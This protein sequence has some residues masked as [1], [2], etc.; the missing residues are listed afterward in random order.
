MRFLVFFTVFTVLYGSMNLYAFVRAKNALSPGPVIS[1]AIGLFLLTMVFSHFLVHLFQG[2]D[3]EVLALVF[4]YAGYTWMAFL[5]LFFCI[6]LSTDVLR[7]ILYLTGFFLKGDGQRF[8]L[9]PKLLFWAG[10][11][12]AMMITCYGYFE[13]LSIKTERITIQSPKIP[14]Q[15]GKIKVAQI[16][17]V[18]LG[19]MVR[20]K[21]L[22]R[23]LKAVRKEN[24][25]ILVSTGDLI[26][27][28]LDH[29]ESA[30]E[31]FSTI[32]PAYG[33]YAVTGN[34][35]FYRGIEQSVNITEQAGFRVLRGE[36][37]KIPGLLNIAGVDDPAGKSFESVNMITEKEVLST[38]PGEDFTILLKHQP[39]LDNASAGLFDLQLS[40]HSH[41]GQ[42]FPFS[43]IIKLLYPVDS[44]L[45]TLDNN[46]LLYVSR[47]SG[48]W[49]PPVRFLAP[50]EIA[51]FTLVHGP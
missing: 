20:E 26:D 11:A 6:S 3:H 8:L 29:I 23:I 31:L 50:P 19:L 24:P 36:A 16:S 40:G 12:L 48:T 47:G 30:I 27:G 35:E 37:V 5:F 51:L 2:K 18:H 34:H 45:L 21:R 4:A 10:I 39:R 41:K 17:D 32:T 43:L 46:S 15:A 42:I 25:D 33:K 38:L 7:G 14:A 49:G 9:S 44:G 13:A 28:Q 22:E 1:A